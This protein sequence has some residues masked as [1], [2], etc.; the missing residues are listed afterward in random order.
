MEKC[1]Q[2]NK[3]KE[4]VCCKECVNEL[5]MNRIAESLEGDSANRFKYILDERIEKIEEK[6]RTFF[7]DKQIVCIKRGKKLTII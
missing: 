5:N 1:C 4:L 3:E 6:I 2:C 7:I